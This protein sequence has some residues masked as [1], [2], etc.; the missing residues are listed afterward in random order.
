ML[1]EL[2]AIA[3]EHQ[4]TFESR[5][6]P[7]VV[8][9]RKDGFPP[10]P[11]VV[12][13]FT[14]DEVEKNYA[15]AKEVFASIIAKEFELS[16]PEPALVNLSTTDFLSTLSVDFIRQMDSRDY[17]IKFG[18]RYINGTLPYNENLPLQH[19]DQFNDIDSIFA[20]DN[21]IH[22]T[23]RNKGKPDNI[24]FKDDYYYLIDH[25][26][27]LSITRQIL[28][29]FED[30]RWVYPYANHV[31]YFYLLLQKDKSDFF[32]HFENK[33]SSFDPNILDSY[34]V[35]LRNHKFN[36]PYQDYQLLKDYLGQIRTKSKTFLNLLK[37][38]V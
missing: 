20:F 25:E 31:F 13:L 28:D 4:I 22:N 5:T 9:A 30:G 8:L 32:L 10:E 27:S 23:D 33:L 26:Y 12:K 18:C 37:G 19:Y 34:E 35:Q 38:F 2:N 29:E 3:F 11:Y 7:W 1:N 6:H 14:K 24:R 36:P 16:M 17:R 21:L 15:V